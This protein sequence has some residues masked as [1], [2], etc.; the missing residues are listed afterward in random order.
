MAEG[1]DFHEVSTINTVV[2]EKT[3]A[4][5]IRRTQNYWTLWAR[6]DRRMASDLSPEVME[7]YKQSLLIIYSQ[8]DHGG[9]VIAANDTDI[10]QFARDTYSYMWPRDG[11]LVSAALLRSGRSEEH[12]S[13]LQSLAYLVCRLLLEKKKNKNHIYTRLL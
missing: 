4:E 3:P 7:R 12:T 10:T 11:A 1:K 2:K 8:I 13:E 6:K 9:A 5:L